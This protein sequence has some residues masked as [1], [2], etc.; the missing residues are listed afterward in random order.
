M[1]NPEQ[2]HLVPTNQTQLQTAKQNYK[3]Q[4]PKSNIPAITAT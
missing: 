2:Y 3:Y 1:K 4:V